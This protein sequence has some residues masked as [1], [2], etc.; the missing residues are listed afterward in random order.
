MELYEDDG[1]EIFGLKLTAFFLWD[2]DVGEP[3]GLGVQASTLRTGGPWLHLHSDGLQEQGGQGDAGVLFKGAG[4]V[5]SKSCLLTLSSSA[6]PSN[7]CLWSKR[8]N[9]SLHNNSNLKRK[10]VITCLRIRKRSTQAKLSDCAKIQKRK[11]LRKSASCFEINS[12]QTHSESS[13][14]S[15]SGWDFLTSSHDSSRRCMSSCKAKAT[16]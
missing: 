1:V 4:W 12:T 6:A 5:C 7:S 16:I 2:E 10:N 13:D 8:A 11:K 15:S 3:A 9:S 14:R